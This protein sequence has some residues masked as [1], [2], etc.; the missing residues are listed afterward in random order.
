MEE[1]GNISLGSEAKRRRTLC[2]ILHNI[3]S[4]VNPD[5]IQCS[6]AEVSDLL[7]SGNRACGPLA[8]P[9]G[10]PSNRREPRAGQ[11]WGG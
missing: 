1:S 6:R 2:T 3:Q 5:K 11:G 4:K 9:V 10:C 7:S 8:G